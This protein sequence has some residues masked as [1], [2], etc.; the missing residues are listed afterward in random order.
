MIVGFGI[1][2]VA[3]AEVESSIKMYGDRYLERIFTAREVEYCRNAGNA[4][5]R[6]AA[7]VAVKEA[8]M[9]ALGTGWD[10]EVE[11]LSFEVVNGPAGPPSLFMHGAAAELAAQNRIA[12][13]WISLSHRADYAMAAVVFE[14]DAL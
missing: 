14:T 13:S 7:R 4:G 5:Q 3:V 10:Q 11:W 1:D 12:R 2:I 6:Y 8:A 9:K